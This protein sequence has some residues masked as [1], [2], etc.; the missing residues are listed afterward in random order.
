[1][2]RA[3]ADV[4]KAKQLQNHSSTVVIDARTSR[5]HMQARIPG[6]ILD[7]W[8]EGLDHMQGFIMSASSPSR[9]SI[10]GG[11]CINNANNFSFNSDIESKKKSN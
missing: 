2:I 6:S 4:I 7:S 5:E 9:M 10:E 11:S 1:M 3:D 8:E